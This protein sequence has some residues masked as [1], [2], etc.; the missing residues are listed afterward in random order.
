M[1]ERLIFYQREATMITGGSRAI[2]MMID[3]AERSS[4]VLLMANRGI[5][6]ELI[7]MDQL[8]FTD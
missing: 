6:K 3:E 1:Q 2:A 5:S 8:L 4:S 7:N